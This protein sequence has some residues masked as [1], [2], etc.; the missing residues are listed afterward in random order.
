MLVSRATHPDAL[1]TPS[2]PA[3]HL[4]IESNPHDR[5]SSFTPGWRIARR[6]SSRYSDA[7][8]RKKS[9]SSPRGSGLLRV[10]VRRRRQCPAVG[11]SISRY[12]QIARREDPCVQL[13]ASTCS[14]LPALDR[15]R[16]SV[17]STTQRF[18]HARPDENYISKRMLLDRA[19][20]IQQRTH[21]DR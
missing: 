19:Q 17:F 11:D 3:A 10:A 15:Q 20:G 7:S 21:Q 8:A 14:K 18:G 1:W 12:P 2:D 16:L 9:C 6:A 5:D 4:R 13:N